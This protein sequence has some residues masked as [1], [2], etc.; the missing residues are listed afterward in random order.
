M[1]R[2]LRSVGTKADVF[3][4]SGRT[5]SLL[6]LSRREWSTLRTGILFISPWIFGFVAF[7]LWPIISSLYYSFTKFDGITT[8][9]W[10]GFDNYQQLIT[11]P[12]YLTAVGNTLYYISIYL[13]VSTALSMGLAILLNQERRGIAIYRTLFFIPSLVPFVASAAIWLWVFNPE[14]GLMN[15]LL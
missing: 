12:V 5:H 13:P 2:L 4:P 7:A 8:P 10:V 14:Y 6:G 1:A 9:A 15:Q 11:D 3:G